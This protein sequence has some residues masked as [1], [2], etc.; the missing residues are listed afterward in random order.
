M[1]TQ[2]FGHATRILVY[3]V[4][5]TVRD[6]T[7]RFR[8]LARVAGSLC[9]RFAN[10]PVRIVAFLRNVSDSGRIPDSRDSSSKENIPGRREI[11]T[12][13]R[14]I[15]FAST[16]RG[17][18]GGGG[19]GG[20]FLP[21]LRLQDTAA[22]PT[23]SLLVTGSPSLLRIYCEGFTFRRFTRGRKRHNGIRRETGERRTQ[24]RVYE[25][26]SVIGN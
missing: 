2:L 15:S 7:C 13:G 18:R 12:S 26:P 4:A 6:C 8:G 9:H 11:S 19:G 10:H 3:P 22:M 24:S 5:W 25:P 21:G 16:C 23:F 14:E 20:Q 17:E 1:R